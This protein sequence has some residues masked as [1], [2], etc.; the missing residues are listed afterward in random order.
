MSFLRVSYRAQLSAATSSLVSFYGDDLL[1]LARN[2]SHSDLRN[3]SPASFCLYGWLDS[4][5]HGRVESG[6]PGRKMYFVRCLQVSLLSRITPP[7]NYLT[8]GQ[9]ATTRT[10][11]DEVRIAV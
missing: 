5:F 2:N 11:R 6:S 8:F 1:K 10:G 7:T 3:A 4:V 9:R